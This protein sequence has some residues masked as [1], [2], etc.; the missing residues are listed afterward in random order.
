MLVIEAMCVMLFNIPA[1][2]QVVESH[3]VNQLSLFFVVAIA[4]IVPL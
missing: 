4:G 1:A 3:E 2:R